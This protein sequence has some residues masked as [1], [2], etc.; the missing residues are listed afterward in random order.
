MTMQ[1][2]QS[3]QSLHRVRHAITLSAHVSE[4]NPGVYVASV[5]DAHARLLWQ[6]V[7]VTSY[8]VAEYLGWFHMAALATR[9][10]DGDDLTGE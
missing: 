10:Q 9:L 6:S 4:V 2:M 8:S 1:S 5:Q 7:P 3:R